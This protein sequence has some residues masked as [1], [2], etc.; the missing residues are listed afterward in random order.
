MFDFINAHQLE[1]LFGLVCLS[2][3][4]GGFWH[5]SIAGTSWERDR[6]MQSRDL[7][8]K[9]RVYYDWEEDRW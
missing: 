3:Y 7:I 5:G 6:L 2:L 1:I 9:K 8:R 4:A